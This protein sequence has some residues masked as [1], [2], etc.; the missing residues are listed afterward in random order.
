MKNL[1]RLLVIGLVFSLFPF[2]SLARAEQKEILIG[3]IPEMN[4]FKQR[5]RFKPLADYLTKKT[6]VKVNLTILSRYGNIIERFTSEK[7]DGAF[8]GS[9]TGALAIQKLGVVPLARPMNLDGSTQYWGYLFVRKDSGIRSVKDMKGKK[10]AFVEK[11]TTAGYVFPEAYFRE[12][13][14]KDINTFFGDYFFAGSHDAA[15]YAVLDKKADIG[16]AKH[17]MYNRVRAADPRVDKELVILA[18]STK[19]PSN[20]LCVRKGLDKGIQKRLKEALL[21]IDKD[22]EGKVVL[23]KFGGIKFIETTVADYNPVFDIAKK[24][25]IDIKKYVYR[26]E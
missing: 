11:A 7:M 14:V 8:F 12:H 22:P 15:I 26:N 6:G 19:V 25:G 16:A 17:S 3:L 5:E 20:G 23:Q 13:G 2:S 9:F 24:A 10:M 21:N 1:A 4:V 18:E